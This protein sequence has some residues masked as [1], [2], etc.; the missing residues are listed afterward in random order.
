M[1]DQH[2]SLIEKVINDSLNEK[3]TILDDENTKVKLEVLESELDVLSLNQIR[4]NRILSQLS[5]FMLT[6]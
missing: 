5:W 4:H 6:I 2:C 3:I 1:A